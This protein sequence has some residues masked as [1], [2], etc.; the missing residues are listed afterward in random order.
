[1]FRHF[2][3]HGTDKAN[4]NKLILQPTAGMILTGYILIESTNEGTGD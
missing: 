1:M 4:V 2:F 3:N